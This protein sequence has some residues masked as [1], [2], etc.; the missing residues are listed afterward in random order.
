M[1]N[2]FP[3][4]IKTVRNYKILRNN[5]Q[6]TYINFVKYTKYSHFNKK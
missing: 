5:R 1:I 2:L 4:S 6:K 3:L